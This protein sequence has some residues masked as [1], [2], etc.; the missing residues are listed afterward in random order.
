M[1]R[2]I[3]FILLVFL[4]S[5]VSLTCA[6][7][8]PVPAQ[9]GV[10]TQQ[11][12]QK[13]ADLE[14][15]IK[16]VEDTSPATTKSVTD[17]KKDLDE[18]KL[19]INLIETRPIP[20]GLSPD[21]RNLLDNLDKR[22]KSLEPTPTP[23]PVPGATPTATPAPAASAAALT[24]LEQR[25]STLEQQVQQ[26]GKQ[27]VSV[28]TPVQ[29]ATP[30]PTPTPKPTI[31]LRIVN[32]SAE[33]DRTKNTITI[34]G[35]VTNLGNINASPIT[36]LVTLYKTGGFALGGGSGTPIIRTLAPGESSPFSLTIRDFDLISY[37]TYVARAITTQ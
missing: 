20:S 11:L 27:P 36:I 33:L 14:K 10:P 34:S 26:L 32:H 4:F 17:L 6:S 5:F 22:V 16:T 35:E 12:N 21:D 9:P 28:P 2:K 1:I 19:R 13:I 25:V 30:T 18:I 7:E 37:Q 23:R 3:I 8:P 29:T 15:R 31:D 24:T